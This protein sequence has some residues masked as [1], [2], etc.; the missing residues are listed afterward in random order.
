MSNVVKLGKKSFPMKKQKKIKS[1]IILSR[2]NLIFINGAI[3][4][5]S[6]IKYSLSIE[7][8]I[9]YSFY[10]LSISTLWTPA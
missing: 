4:L 2:S 3:S 10:E 9:S 1:S 7:M 6:S 5:Y 8:W